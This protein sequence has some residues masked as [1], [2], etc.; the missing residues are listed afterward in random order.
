MAIAGRASIALAALVL[1]LVASPSGGRQARAAPQPLVVSHFTAVELARVAVNEDSRPLRNGGL[2]TADTLAIIQ[3]VETVA[4]LH[5]YSVLTAL[6]RLAPHVTKQRPPKRI[7]HLVS[8]T[9]PAVGRVRPEHWVEAIDGPWARYGRDWVRFRG[10]VAKLLREGF[11]RPCPGD[12]IAWGGA[13]DDWI[14][15]KRKLVRLDCGDRNRFWGR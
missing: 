3:T 14:A 10:N 7:R 4:R 15:E 5:G 9:L 1:S 6:Q 11:E 12:P 2:P 8:A 13:M